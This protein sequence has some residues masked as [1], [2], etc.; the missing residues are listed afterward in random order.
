MFHEAGAGGAREAPD[1]HDWLEVTALTPLELE[2]VELLVAPE[3]VELVAS[4]E[5]PVPGELEVVVAAA[6]VADW[7]TELRASAGSWP[8]TST[9]VMSIHT[10]RN[11]ATDPPIT[12]ARIRRTRAR[13]SSLNLMPSCL[14]MAAASSRAIATACERRKKTV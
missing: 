10:A 13:R 1:G 14:V 5:V 9:T 4:D 7:V 2:P 8:V 11:R 12:R 6:G 3:L